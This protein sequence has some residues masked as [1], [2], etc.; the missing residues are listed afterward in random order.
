MIYLL[1]IV[2]SAFNLLSGG[3]YLVQVVKGKSVPNPATWLIWVIV[4]IINMFTYFF[5]VKGSVWLSLSSIV[6]ACGILFIFAFS[7]LKGK[8]SK[9]GK[10][11]ITC[12]ALSFV[13]GLFWRLSGNS[14]VSNIAIQSIFLISFYPTLIALL[15]MQTK[16]KPLAWFFASTSYA[17]QIILVLTS[18]APLYGLIFP[19]VNL[20]GNGTIGIVALRQN[21][22]VKD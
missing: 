4:T 12:L 7:L 1:P 20:I 21:T 22:D 3:T 9:L 8:F 6:L 18:S 16:E 11:E 2:A 10:L 13:I 14:I 15:N 17:L 19:I 5:V